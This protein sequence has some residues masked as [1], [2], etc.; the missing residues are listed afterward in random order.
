[1]MMMTMMT[2]MMKHTNSVYRINRL[3]YSCLLSDPAYEW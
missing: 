3:F 1:M 2:M